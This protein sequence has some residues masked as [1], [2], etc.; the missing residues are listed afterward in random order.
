MYA[1]RDEAREVAVDLQH[2]LRSTTRLSSLT[3]TKGTREDAGSSR[4]TIAGAIS[5]LH[6]ARP[7][8]S[9][10]SKKGQAFR[11]PWKTSTGQDP[12]REACVLN[13]LDFVSLAASSASLSDGRSLATTLAWLQKLAGAEIRAQ[14]DVQFDAACARGADAYRR[15]TPDF[16]EIS[17]EIE[18]RVSIDAARGKTGS[19]RGFNPVVAH[20][21]ANGVWRHLR[22]FVGHTAHQPESAGGLLQPSPAQEMLGAARGVC[23]AHQDIVDVRQSLKAAHGPSSL[24]RDTRLRAR[25]INRGEVREETRKTQ[26][27][28]PSDVHLAHFG[29]VA[30]LASALEKTTRTFGTPSE[31]ELYSDP[32]P[33]EGHSAYHSPTPNT[34][35]KSRLSFT[36]RDKTEPAP[37]DDRLSPVLC[38]GLAFMFSVD[39]FLQGSGGQGLSGLAFE[40]EATLDVSDPR[41]AFAL[42]HRADVRERIKQTFYEQAL[43]LLAWLHCTFP[44]RV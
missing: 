30:R 19:R 38:P 13:C 33:V 25:T 23:S 11:L 35:A 43:L 2:K 32:S 3:T 41:C 10:S 37:T 9:P 5:I 18:M 40:L 26:H 12:L 7:P 22:E 14:V 16:D 27:R 1:S 42:E 29:Q 36:W 24:R 6:A 39:R 21:S 8:P 34:Q 28:G 15:R 17:L 31:V 20:E 44:A 4:D